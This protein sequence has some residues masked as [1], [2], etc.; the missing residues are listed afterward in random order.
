MSSAEIPVALVTKKKPAATEGALRFLRAHLVVPM[1][2]APV[3]IALILVALGHH[4][5]SGTRPALP[6][7]ANPPVD[8]SAEVAQP[9]TKPQ[10]VGISDLEGRSTDSL[11]SHEL[12]L[13]A[14]AHAQKQSDAA[15]QLRQKIEANPA[16]GKDSATQ[17]ELLHLAADARTSRDALGAM[18]AVEAPIAQDLLYEVW[19]GT[20]ERSDTTE[21][22]R[23]LLYSTDLRKG[24]SPALSVALGLRSAETCEQ[25]KALLPQAVTQQRVIRMSR[26]IFF[27]Q[28]RPAHRG[29]NTED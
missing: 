6:A 26:L 8:Y 11:N 19:A 16:L 3:L 13:L 22:A 1:V 24:A 25:F 14:Q 4:K 15:A 9:L 23:T 28:E 20:P 5:S 27:R 21:L 7:T 12:L 17:S 18:A 2:G 10:P 29:L